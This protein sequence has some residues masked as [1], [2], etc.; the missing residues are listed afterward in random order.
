MEF[1]ARMLESGV[2]CIQEPRSTF[3]ARVAHCSDPDG[4]PI[5]V[6]ER[7]RGA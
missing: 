1:H 5:S 6:S 3:G 4:M 2:R 7:Q